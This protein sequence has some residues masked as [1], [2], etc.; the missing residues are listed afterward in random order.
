MSQPCLL[1]RVVFAVLTAGSVVGAVVFAG[2]LVSALYSAAAKASPQSIVVFF[3][4]GLP[5]FSGVSA[6]ILGFAARKQVMRR[7]SVGT[8][9]LALCSVAF[10]CFI[11]LEYFYALYASGP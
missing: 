4:A 9:I 11:V 2:T 10:I 1:D 3:I 8:S 7:A 5:M 6:L